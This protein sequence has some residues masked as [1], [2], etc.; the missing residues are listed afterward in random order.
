MQVSEQS[1]SIALPEESGALP[2]RKT[3]TR[4]ITRGGPGALSAAGYDPATGTWR[5]VRRMSCL[6]EATRA[7][8]SYAKALVCRAKGI[9]APTVLAVLAGDR[10]ADVKKIV[11]ATGG[12]KGRF[13]PSEVAEELTGCA[14]GATPPLWLSAGL[15]VAADAEF[16][17]AHAEI[18]FNAVRLD[19]SV[20][21]S[22]P[23]DATSAS[24]IR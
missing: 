20:A 15:P 16:L 4:G 10:R 11:A 21:M 3:G 13:A 9:D 18:A 22:P 19:R 14:T 24:P 5:P 2:F 23:T 12:R 6:A 17:A 8:R 1:G 7:W